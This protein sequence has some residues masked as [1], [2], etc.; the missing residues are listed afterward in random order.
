MTSPP[1]NEL[2]ADYSKYA[3]GSSLKYPDN[4]ESLSHLMMFNI[5]VNI[6]S[7]EGQ[8]TGN[9]G[10][11]ISRRQAIRQDT[12]GLQGTE[13]ISSGHAGLE[14]GDVKIQSGR[15]TKR[16]QQSIA[17]YVP[18]TMV[19]DD[20]QQY[21]DV[22]LTKEFGAGATLGAQIGYNTGKDTFAGGAIGAGVGIG[23]AAAL[24]SIAKSFANGADRVGEFG[25]Q[26]SGTLGKA[27][28]LTPKLLGF[29]MNPMIEVIYQ[30]PTMRQF[31]FDFLFAPRSPAETN[32]VVQIIK[33]F[34]RHMAPEFNPTTGIQGAAF[35]PPSEFD[36]SFHVNNKGSFSENNKIPRI[37]TCVLK[38][39]NTNYAPTQFATFNDGM[40]VQIQMRLAFQE[41]DLI[42]RE[43]IDA[44][45]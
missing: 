1:L 7:K 24:S 2:S 10:T 17:L 41:L 42:T 31:Q 44:G 39:M 21:E 32:S 6:Y 28:N 45:F 35:L 15:K 34:R 25:K 16:I 4:I 11:G 12:G 29:A 43:R 23:A 40:P 3:G 36:I 9:E 30:Q 5:N 22:S 14:V 38:T 26:I 20:A 27:A 19:F 33:M 13:L 37:S 8:K 18:D